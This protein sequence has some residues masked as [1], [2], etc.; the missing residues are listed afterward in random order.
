M[1]VEREPF[2]SD[3]CEKDRGF[4]RDP[5][6]KRLGELPSTTGGITR[7]A[8]AQAKE[9]GLDL[10]LL[11]KKAGLTIH[12]IEDSSVRLKVRDQISFLVRQ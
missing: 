6:T 2:I 10:N 1:P 9:V 11:L 8:Y 5:D 4:V 12:Q 7:L 3:P